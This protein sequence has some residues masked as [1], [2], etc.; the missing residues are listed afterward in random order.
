MN[1]RHSHLA[2]REWRAHMVRP[3]TIAALIGVSAILGVAGPFETGDVLRLIPRIIYWAVIVVASYSSGV[4]IGDLLGPKLATWPAIPRILLTG[5]LTGIAVCVIVLLVNFA[6]I[7]FFPAPAQWI[8]FLAPIIA[9]SIIIT[10]VAT[11]IAQNQAETSSAAKPNDTPALLDRLPF[12]KRGQLIAISVEDHY[13]RIQ[14]TKG[15]DLILLRLSDAIREVGG[16][17]GAQ[18]HRSH[19]VAFDQVRAAH[20]DKDRGQLTMSNGATI[21][22]SRSNIPKIKEAGLLPR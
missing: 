16:T 2:L 3:P 6:A 5:I 7:G 15:E 17:H 18:V 21:P 12:D 22:V 19:W 10:A 13:V 14:T 9:I 4:L 11:I 20:R 8:A 1:D